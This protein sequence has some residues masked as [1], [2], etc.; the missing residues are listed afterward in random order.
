M[1][2]LSIDPGTHPQQ[3]AAV[4]AHALCQALT[5]AGLLEGLP[6]CRAEVEDGDAVVN[7]GQVSASTAL[8]LAAVI[9]RGA[10]RRTR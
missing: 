9:S 4:A 7:L 8:A 3:R 1:T 6:Q 2:T 10:Q 5:A